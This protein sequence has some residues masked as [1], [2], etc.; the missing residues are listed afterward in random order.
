MTT[1]PLWPNRKKTVKQEYQGP[2]Q[3]IALTHSSSICLWRNLHDGVTSTTRR[4]ASVS[5]HARLKNYSQTCFHAKQAARCRSMH[6]FEAQTKKPSRWFWGSNHQTWSY[7]FLGPN[8]KTLT[9]LI[10]R[11][12]Q[13]TD[14]IDF[15]AKLAKIIAAG[16]E[17]KPLETVATGFEVKPV[18]TVRVVLRS[19]HSQTINLGFKAQP[20]N[21]RS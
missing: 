8:R 16:F 17:A 2:T 19:N 5:L 12:N 15:E 6:G 14:A 18:K 20:R 11:L 10:L 3:P 1:T 9:T 13:E 4:H 21:P 7:H